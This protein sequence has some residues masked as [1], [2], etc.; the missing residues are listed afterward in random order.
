MDTVR[1]GEEYGKAGE[2]VLCVKAQ[3]LEK[4]ELGKRM[5]STGTEK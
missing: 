4:L 5:S 1:G 2:L 3:R